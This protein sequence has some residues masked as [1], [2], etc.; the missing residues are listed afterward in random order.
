VTGRTSLVIRINATN[1]TATNRGLHSNGGAGRCGR[2]MEW[3]QIQSVMAV[4]SYLLVYLIRIRSDVYWIGQHA[5]LNARVTTIEYRCRSVRPCHVDRIYG[6]ASD[7][8]GVTMRTE[9]DA[10]EPT[11]IHAKARV[12]IRQPFITRI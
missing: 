12:L 6:E 4:N 8:G 11:P 5:A 10:T 3:W 2:E 9:S 7:A 1:A